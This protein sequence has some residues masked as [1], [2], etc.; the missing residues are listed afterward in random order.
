MPD[1]YEMIVVASSTPDLATGTAAVRAA[2][3]SLRSASSIRGGTTRA[4]LVVDWAEGPAAI[5]AVPSS[6]TIEACGAPIPLDPD[7][8][9]EHHAELRR[10]AVG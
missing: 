4:R 7:H 8:R 9:E 10:A 1:T 3:P 6:W 5:A 2:A